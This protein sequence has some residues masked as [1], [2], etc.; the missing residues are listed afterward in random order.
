MPSLGV[1]TDPL[2]TPLPLLEDEEE[3]QRVAAEELRSEERKFVA[4]VFPKFDM[5]L[6]TLLDSTNRLDCETWSTIALQMFHTLHVLETA[7]IV[8]EDLQVCGWHFENVQVFMFL[9]YA[10]MT[11]TFVCVCV[12]TDVFR[13]RIGRLCPI[14]PETCIGRF[15]WC[16][17]ELNRLL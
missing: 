11:F 1:N 2:H 4:F 7:G 17:R 8:D 16:F 13:L 9:K 14:L 6:Q 3:V 15:E 12:G 10:C 5:T